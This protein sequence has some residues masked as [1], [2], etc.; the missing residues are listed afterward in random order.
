MFYKQILAIFVQKDLTSNQLCLKRCLLMDLLYQ[1][2]TIF[3]AK[4]I[5]ATVTNSQ[6]NTL[7]IFT[8]ESKKK[9]RASEKKK[10]EKKEKG[11]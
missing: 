2:G 1:C 11:S 3:K 6:I 8:S 5:K 4:K 10:K 9:Y 7:T